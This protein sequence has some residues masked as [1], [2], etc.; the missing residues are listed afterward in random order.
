MHCPKYLQLTLPPSLFSRFLKDGGMYEKNRKSFV[1]RGLLIGIIVVVILIQVQNRRQKE[2]DETRIQD[3]EQLQA[4]LELYYDAHQIYPMA[5]TGTDLNMQAVPLDPSTGR[6]YAYDQV[7]GG[8]W[9]YLGA[10]L[11]TRSHTVLN[12]DA[13]SAGTNVE[14]KDNDGCGNEGNLYC[15]DVS[16]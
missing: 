5:L 6:V 3:I 8:S 16:H 11:E 7:D 2:Y 9:Y 13:D 14:G 1:L 10:N 15:Y 4:A 12:I